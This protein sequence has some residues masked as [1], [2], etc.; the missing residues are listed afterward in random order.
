M[1]SHVLYTK[2]AKRYAKTLF[3]LTID[4]SKAKEGR[5]DFFKKV[6]F[7]LNEAFKNKEIG[8]FFT[9]PVISQEFKRKLVQTFLK[10]NFSE[11]P[12]VEKQDFLTIEHF[13]LVLIEKNRLSLVFDIYTQYTY[14]IDKA[15]GITRVDLTS[16][17][18]LNDELKQAVLAGVKKATQASEVI[19]EKIDIDSTLLGGCKVHVGNKVLD[20]SLKS[21]IKQML[22]I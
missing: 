14:L 13:L 12:K 21:E 5:K 1:S 15:L 7:T 18:E 2:I 9:S 22:T 16:A 17:L 10:E 20:L 6:L 3:S 8:F 19:L 11:E 4:G